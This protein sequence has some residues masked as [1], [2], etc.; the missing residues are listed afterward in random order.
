MLAI[1]TML[2]L[3]VH[4]VCFQSGFSAALLDEDNQGNVQPPRTHT[5]SQC[6]GLKEKGGS[7]VSIPISLSPEGQQETH[8]QHRQG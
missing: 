5:Y 2:S 6:L 1:S 7:G 3:S 4:T 8:F